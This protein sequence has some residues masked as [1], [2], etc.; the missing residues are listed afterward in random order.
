MKKFIGFYI[1]ILSALASLVGVAAYA[2]NCR[3][4]YFLSQGMSPAVMGGA[5]AAVAV[6]IVYLIATKNGH[7]TWTDLLAVVPPVL[8]VVATVTLLSVRVNGIAAIMTFESNAQNLSDLSSAIVAIA[9]CAAAIVV[10]VLASFFD[11]VRE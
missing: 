1:T 3:T 10:G 6:Q 7:Q 4:N 5:I 2:V 8:M 9:A 11:T